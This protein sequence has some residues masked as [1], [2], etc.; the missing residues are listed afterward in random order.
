[1]ALL[2]D[3]D[4]DEPDETEETIVPLPPEAVKRLIRAMQW[5]EDLEKYDRLNAPTRLDEMPI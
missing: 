4:M 5:P 1:M 3:T 2:G